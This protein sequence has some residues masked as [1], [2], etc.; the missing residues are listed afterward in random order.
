M[1]YHIG[2]KYGGMKIC[3]CLPGKKRYP[4]GGYKIIYEYANRL[5]ERGH[6]VTIAYDYAGKFGRW[7]VIGNNKWLKH[8]AIYV[9]FGSDSVK[10]FKLNKKVRQLNCLDGI[11]DDK[12]PDSDFVF[13]TSVYTVENV[14][15][16]S[17]SKGK[18]C[19]FVQGIENWQISDDELNETYRQ[20]D[21]VISISEWIKKRVDQ[22]AQ[23]KS[24][25]IPN[26][27]NF[28]E[29]YVTSSIEKRNPLT[30]SMLYHVAVVKG[31][32][33]GI[34]ALIKLKERYP[35][36]VVKMFGTTKKGKEIPE[37]VDYTNSA[38]R[39][40]LLEIYNSSAIFLCPTIDE[41]FGL[42]GAEAMACGCALVSTAY[43]GN[44]IYA[45]DGKNSVLCETQNSQA[46]YE[47][48]LYLIQHNEHRIKLAKQG[49]QDIKALDW[50]TVVY[51]FEKVL[52][53]NI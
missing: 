27:I 12:L 22:Y 2:R 8:M 47:S 49:V 41:G 44:K 16:L 24:Y 37:W 32:K 14:Q 11:S 50:D 15:K 18:K 9:L 45:Q 31:S 25:L 52:N 17:E 33:Y 35:E 1:L 7:P 48:M 3:F 40:Q 46:L 28:N 36:L 4:M 6:D 20:F 39:K 30:V 29:F 13:A 42:T 5:S 53:D 34:E 23:G 43:E 10:W 38:N 26:G 19:Y 21:V 51:K